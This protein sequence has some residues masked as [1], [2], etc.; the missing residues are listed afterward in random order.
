[1]PAIQRQGYI[2]RIAPL[3]G[4]IQPAEN[5]SLSINRW[6]STEYQTQKEVYI[7][8]NIGFRPVFVRSYNQ[9]HYSLFR[10]AK[11][12]GG[13][14]GEDNYLFLTSYIYNYTGENYIGDEKILSVA[15]RMKY[16]Q[17]YFRSKNIIILTLLLPSKASFFPE[18]IPENYKVFPKSNYSEYCYLFDSLQINY[19]DVNKYFQEIKDKTPY[20]LFPKNG[21]H[22]SSYGMALGMDTLIK[23][24]EFLKNID[25]PDMTWDEPIPMEAE[26]KDPDYDAE[27][28]MN[29]YL[30]LPRE[31]MPYPKF[32]FLMDSTKTRAR[33]LVISDSY[34][35]QAY[36]EHIPHEVFDWGGFWYYCNTARRQENHKEIVTPVAELDLQEE[37]LQ[38]DV[39]VLFASQA[40]MHLYPYG[41]DEKA[42]ELFKPFDTLALI[43]HYEKVIRNDAKWRQ[44]VEE[45][46]IKNQISFEEQ[47]K[48]DAEWMALNTK[49]KTSKKADEI[50]KLIRKIK[51]DSKWLSSVQKKAKERNISL[52]EMLRLDAEFIF[53]KNQK[54]QE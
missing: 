11:N 13:V 47:L 39:I 2:F 43:N 8:E 16:L 40:T 32:N 30:D 33:T 4:F 1:M 54:N 14:V 38:Q 18:Y 5:I 48:N 34:Y 53:E 52:D 3:N 37:L 23:K 42:Y 36:T 9:I 28:L 22:W 29:L 24:I 44:S 21:L 15:E 41:F 10:M 26:N 35:W 46:A 25:L 12:P 49:K 31:R 27:N 51:S 19:I 20:P 6:F 50:E 17:D 45:K 7:K